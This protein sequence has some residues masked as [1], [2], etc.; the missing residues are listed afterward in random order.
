MVAINDN[1]SASNGDLTACPS[2]RASKPAELAAKSRQR[3]VLLVDDHVDSLRPMTLLLRMEGFTVLPAGSFDDAMTL[4]QKAGSVDVLVSDVGLRDR[5]GLEL[6]VRVRA[7]HPATRGVTISGHDDPELRRAS[8][9]AGYLG[10]LVKPISIEK[11]TK[12]LRA[13][14]EPQAV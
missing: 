9:M 3:V 8:A 2:E 14:F 11:L 13:I 7:M 10:H 12:L 6:L 1:I 4:A 5:S